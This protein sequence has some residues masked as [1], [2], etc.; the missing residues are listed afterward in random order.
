M[1]IRTIEFTDPDEVHAFHRS[2]KDAETA[3]NPDRP[4]WSEKDMVAELTE[5]DD[6][7]DPHAFGAFDADGRLLGGSLLFIPLLDNLTMAFVGAFVSPAEQGKG[8]GSALVEHVL[9]QVRSA[10]RT[11]VLAEASYGFEH[12]DDHRSRRFAERHGFVLASTEVS[13]RL[14]LPIAETQLQAWMDEAAPHH[15]AYR[16]ETFVDHVPDALL[17]SLCHVLNQLALDAPTGSIDFE[18]EQSTPQVRRQHDARNKKIG[19]RRYDTVAIDASGDVVAASAIGVPDDDSGRVHQW[20]TIVL[21]AHRGHRLGLA[22]KAHNLRAVQ[23]A[24]PDRQSVHTCNEE[25]NAPM[26]DINERFGFKP[27]ELLVEFLRNLDG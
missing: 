27:V 22:L 9:E 26:V 20:S 19:L 6:A 2:F 11:K 1:H 3:E 13:R 25:N 8:V 15:E 24:H 4:M 17:P 5:P 10:G 16:V 7:E 21:H 14:D 18:A 23:R 12:R